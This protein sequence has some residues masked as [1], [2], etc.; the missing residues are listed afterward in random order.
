MTHTQYRG[1]L[2]LQAGTVGIHTYAVAPRS[3]HALTWTLSSAAWKED[4]WSVGIRRFKEG[5]PGALKTLISVLEDGLPP[6]LRTLR[7]HDQPLTLLT[8]LPA[9]A[10]CPDPRAP[11]HR[12][13]SSVQT[14]LHRFDADLL[15][16][17]RHPQLQGLPALDRDKAVSHA[18]TAHLRP[19]MRGAGM[20]RTLLDLS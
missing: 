18:Y 6:L 14:G 19:S 11:L 17:R 3:I 8:A 10:T 5:N 13:A 7:V 15:S 9:S 4:E 20:S 12:L 2:P 1:W 16:K